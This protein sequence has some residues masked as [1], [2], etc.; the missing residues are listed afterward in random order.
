MSK[1]NS[2]IL[3]FEKAKKVLLDP[4]QIVLVADDNG[5]WSGITI[6]KAHIVSTDIEPDEYKELPIPKETKEEKE[7]RQKEIRKLLDEMRRKLFTELSA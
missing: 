4:S 3:P 1:G 6:N 2:I 7:A 5:E